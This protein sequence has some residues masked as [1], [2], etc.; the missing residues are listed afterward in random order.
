MR[1]QFG[2]ICNQC[3]ASFE[4]ND[5]PGMIAMPLHFDRCGKVWWWEFGFHGPTGDPKA[6]PCDCGGIYMEDARPL[7]PSCGSAEWKHD[8][9]QPEVMYD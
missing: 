4:V 7:S 9:G 6:P 5:G 3:G 2:A 1:K 8:P